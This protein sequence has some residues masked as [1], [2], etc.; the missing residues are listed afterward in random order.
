LKETSAYFQ[1][2]VDTTADSN[3]ECNSHA[4]QIQQ[5]KQTRGF[6]SSRGICHKRCIQRLVKRQ[7]SKKENPNEISRQWMM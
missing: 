3:S 7:Q 5:S 6:P 4:Q 2:A 1:A